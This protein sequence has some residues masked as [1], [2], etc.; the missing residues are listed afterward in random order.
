MW[1]G[2]R[3][4]RWSSRSR[5]SDRLTGREAGPHADAGREKRRDHVEVE[6]PAPGAGDDHATEEG[7][8]HPRD[9]PRRALQA[10]EHA[11]MPRRQVEAV[12]QHRART[13]AEA[14]EPADEA[15]DEIGRAHV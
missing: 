5:E 2:R 11:G 12:D 4:R 6:I 3:A 14:G 7:G 8:D 15:G 13:E 1:D 9:V 10:D